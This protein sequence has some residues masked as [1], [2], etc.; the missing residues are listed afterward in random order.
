MKRLSHTILFLVITI[1]LAISFTSCTSTS[2]LLPL[3]NNS[4]KAEASA[5]DYEAMSSKISQLESRIEQ[6]EQGLDERVIEYNIVKSALI[7]MVLCHW[8][9]T[10]AVGHPPTICVSSLLLIP[11]S[12]DMIRI[13]MVNLIPTMS[14]L[15]QVN[16]STDISMTYR[17]NNFPTWDGLI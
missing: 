8:V 6:L 17:L 5:D 2:E 3:L 15:R 7:Q 13:K 11:P 16:G 14:R 9:R 10:V 1:V 12:L 4:A